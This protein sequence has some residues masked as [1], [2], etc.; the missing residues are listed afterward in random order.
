MA[1][2]EGTVDP[3]DLTD[4]QL[5]AAQQ[6]ADQEAAGT[7]PVVNDGEEP[8][9]EPEAGAAK[10]AAAPAP[11]PE[12][13][14]EP[15][16]AP[17]PAP[18]AA[19]EAGADKGKIE[20]VLSKDGKTVL[21]YG[22]LQAARRD[23]RR[24]EGRASALEQELAAAKQ[25]LD[26]MKSGKTPIEDITEDDVK[27]ME[28]DFPDQGAK[29]RR[30]W[31]RAQAVPTA[32]PKP[33]KGNE[34]DDPVL[35]VQEIIDQVPLLLEWQHA[36]DQTMWTRAI[37]HDALLLKSPKWADKPAVERFAEATRRTA[38][39]YDIPFEK[40]KASSPAA[41]PAPTSAPA[42]AKPAEKEPERRTPETLS[43]FKSGATPDHGS[44]DL[45]G[46]NPV[47]LL[48][49][50]QDMTDEEIDAQLAK[51]G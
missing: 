34:D 24:A 2:E 29:M 12:P 15:T 30:L 6:A 16:P 47:V 28:A 8:V 21:P 46:T 11:T 10:A 43:E 36:A 20:G 4:E 48:G 23:A 38:D 45:R 19:E 27:Q 41:S 22:S 33:D 50:F 7:D 51:L 49:K 18:A 13:T 40:P 14:P 42:A 39:E 1:T 32:A 31:E 17:T 9:E 26:D 25:Q 37:E 5:E 35:K 3:A 44:L